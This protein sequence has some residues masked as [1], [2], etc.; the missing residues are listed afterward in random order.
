LIHIQPRSLEKQVFARHLC[1]SLEKQMPCIGQF[2]EGNLGNRSASFLSI[3][4]NRD[5]PRTLCRS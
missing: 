2:F 5:E 4:P 1:P 3:L